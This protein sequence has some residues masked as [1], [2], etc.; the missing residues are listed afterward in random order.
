MRC[1]AYR[2]SDVPE[3]KRDFPTTEPTK[4]AKQRSREIKLCYVGE[5][6]FVV[7]VFIWLIHTPT[8]HPPGIW[9]HPL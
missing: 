3:Q 1:V 2:H 7:T 8:T 9:P 4:E 5:P 6:I